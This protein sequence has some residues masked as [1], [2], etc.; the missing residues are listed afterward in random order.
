MQIEKGNFNIKILKCLR[1]IP[2]H[3]HMISKIL[4]VFIYGSESL[5]ES[6]SKGIEAI[7]V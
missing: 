7:E 1:P 2:K 4:S 5:I 3:K 6:T